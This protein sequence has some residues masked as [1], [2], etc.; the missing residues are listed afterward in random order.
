M[1]AEELKTRR[2]PSGYHVV[3]EVKPGMPLGPFREE[4]VFQTDHPKQ[5]ELKVTVA[6]KVIGP[7]SVFPEKLGCP[8]SRA[9]RGLRATSALIVRGGKETQFRGGPCA[10]EAPGGHRA[11]RQA[12]REGPVSHEGHRA[13][14]TPPGLLDDPIIL[15]TD[16]PKVGELKIPVTIYISRSNAG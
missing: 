11:G 5:P 13:P 8:A 16:H 10:G 4:L 12:G 2:V 1:T 6:G 15:K 3:V 7:I 14:G 9:G